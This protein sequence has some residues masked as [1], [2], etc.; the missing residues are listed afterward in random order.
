M[1]NLEVM[2]RAAG[3]SQRQLAIKICFSQA[4]LSYIESEKVNVDGVSDELREAL[5]NEFRKPLEYLLTEA[6]PLEELLVDTYR[7]VVPEEDER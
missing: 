3:L 6:R 7:D 2:R 5:E 1:I 4:A